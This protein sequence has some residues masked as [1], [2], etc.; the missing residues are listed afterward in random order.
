MRFLRKTPLTS[1]E[2]EGDSV[3]AGSPSGGV[4][5]S[6]RGGPGRNW[7][8]LWVAV[9]RYT[10]LTIATFLVVAGLTGSALSFYRELDGL[11]NPGLVS[12][13]ERSPDAEPM[14]PLALRKRIMEKIPGWRI[15]SL[16]LDHDPQFSTVFWQKLESGDWRSVFVDP[17]A[18]EV[19]GF[20]EG[21]S[22]SG[23]ISYLMPFL[24]QLHYELALG[25]TGVLLFGIVALLWTIDCFVGFYLS[26]PPRSR[27]RRESRKS[28]SWLSRWK[29]SWLV[30]GGSL[31]R[32]L[33]TFHRASGLWVWPM[34]FVF[35]WSAVGFNLGLVYTPVMKL[36][37]TGPDAHGQL[38]DLDQPRM[39]PA[40]AWPDALEKA[41]DHMA[42]EA[43]TRDFT[44]GKEGW[45]AYDP[46]HGTYQYRVHT[47]RDVGTRYPGTRLWFD[48]NSGELLS[49]R[50]PT[51]IARGDT[52][53]S[54]LFALHMGTV[55]GLVYRIFVC[56]LGFVIAGLSFTGVYIWWKKSRARRRG[57]SPS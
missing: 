18:G 8:S 13:P 27:L 49:F 34:L 36:F 14:D 11:I 55:G 50:S 43:V 6:P 35:A 56:V 4:A 38:P 32:T 3:R 9:H 21:S 28:K 52:I 22:L 40:L 46:S 20:R 33:F 31:F 44:V 23:G 48:G 15:D 30:K 25:K 16:V 24:Y 42:K 10:G 26:L 57:K 5:S 19:L 12:L 17:Y 2:L 39:N 41:R 53:S 47:S 37:G 1:G 54:W 7:R 45:L 51:G 29:P